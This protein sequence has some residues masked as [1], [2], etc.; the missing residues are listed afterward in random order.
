MSAHAE[1]AHALLSASGAKKWIA[2][3]PSAR[4]ED[5]MVDESSDHAKAGT[6]AHEIS[7]AVLRKELGLIKGATLKRK[8]TEFRK[9]SLFEE[10]MIDYCQ[11]YVDLVMERY[12]EALAVTPDAQISIEERLDFSAW[13]PDGFG[14][15]DVLIVANDYVE[16]IDLKYGKGIKVD[17]V[18][19][20]QTRLYGLGAYHA[21]A[22]FY[23]FK[24][25]K[26]TIIQPRLD[27]IDTEVMA[28][29][30][31]ID[32]AEDIVVPSAELA[33]AGVGEFC[34]GSHCTASFCKVRETCRARA[35]AN[36]AMA[37]YDFKEGPLLTVDEI[38]EILAK[39]DE[40]QKWANDIQ[41]FALK[42]AE[43][44]VKIPGWKLVEGRSNRKYEDEEAVATSLEM[45]GFTDDQIYNK[46]IKGVTE[47]TK[48]LGKK[49]FETYVGPY[50]IKPPGKPA[51]VSEADGRPELNTLESQIKDF[52]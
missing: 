34:A 27:H 50:I 2:C 44:G 51:L 4:L 37:K 47:L 9:I 49:K 18:D 6:L 46:K 25:V 11:Q 42:Q 43:N 23:D 12:H 48:A 40:L 28:V 17:A 8:M 52:D 30:D 19:N 38:G 41:G 3:P 29:E 24:Q 22:D 33:H 45:E 39:A 36:L 14:T 16:V 7:E 32:W 31:L 1:R 35:E 10:E 26:M 5:Q 13:V 20:P 15:G 21:Y